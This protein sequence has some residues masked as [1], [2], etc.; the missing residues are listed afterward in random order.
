MNEKKSS[1]IAAIKGI[2]GSNR[3][4]FI[5]IVYTVA[6]LG[7]VIK[8]FRDRI[9]F[10]GMQFFGISLSDLL[11]AELVDMLQAVANVLFV[12]SLSPAYAGLFFYCILAISPPCPL[13]KMAWAGTAP[14]TEDRG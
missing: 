1:P 11:G 10:E 2:L 3:L 6:A 4:L 5:C 14:R 12:I 9:D 7:N 8:A 13:L